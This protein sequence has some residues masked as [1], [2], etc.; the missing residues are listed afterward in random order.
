[1][2]EGDGIICVLVYPDDDQADVWFLN[3]AFARSSSDPKAQKVLSK[4]V[5]ALKDPNKCEE[6]DLS[7]L[8]DADRK[9]WVFPPC[10]VTDSVTIY[11]EH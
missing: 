11:M 5:K 6:M 8:W 7:D 10:I 9:I 3:M 2:I 4:V 1:M